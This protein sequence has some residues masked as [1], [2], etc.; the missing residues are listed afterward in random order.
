M[1]KS[2]ILD[3][4]RVHLSQGVLT[5]LEARCMNEAIAAA[6]IEGLV[7]CESCNFQSAV[8]NGD[9][10]ICPSCERKQCRFCPRI[11]DENHFAKTCDQ[12]THEEHE[13]EREEQDREYA[14]L[15]QEKYEKEHEAEQRKQ[16]VEQERLKVEQERHK[17]EQERI[18]AIDEDLRRKE[19][20]IK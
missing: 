9:Y 16:R 4:V 6:D 7:T 8:T 14:E 10:F 18:K 17:A 11:Y 1:L 12:V 13:R 5:L 20:N 2:A 19:K 15:L 3:E